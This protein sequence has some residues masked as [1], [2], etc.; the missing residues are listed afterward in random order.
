MARLP[1]RRR[2]SGSP[3]LWRIASAYGECWKIT[4]STTTGL[5]A[6]RA[7]SRLLRRCRIRPCR[8][9]RRARLALPSCLENLHIQPGFLVVALLQRGVVAGELELVHMLEL[10]RDFSSAMPGMAASSRRQRRTVWQ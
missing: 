7:S 3:P 1:M 2:R 8:P 10:Q 9:A 6:S 4:P 5:P